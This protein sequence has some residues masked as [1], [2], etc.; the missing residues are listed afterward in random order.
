MIKNKKYV[1]DS[2]S[3]TDKKKQEKSIKSGTLE[4]RPKVK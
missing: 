2:L 4:D 1:P 3:N